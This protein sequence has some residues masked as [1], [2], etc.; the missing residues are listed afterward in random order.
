MK[1]PRSTPVLPAK[2]T[3][4]AAAPAR[5]KAK[6][7]KPVSVPSVD[8]AASAEFARIA[9]SFAGAPDLDPGAASKGFG[10]GALKV[11]G[12]IFAMVSSR[13]QF[14]VKLARD[15]VAALVADGIGEPFDPGHGRKMKEWLALSGQPRRWKAL[16]EEAYAF[17]RSASR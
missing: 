1:T 16:A 7:P 3:R 2:P 5:P 8:G 10:S 9:A 11:N 12:K 13:G 4:T 17:V 6:E 14:V 15:R